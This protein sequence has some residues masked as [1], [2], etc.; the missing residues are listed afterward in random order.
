MSGIRVVQIDREERLEFAEEGI[1]GILLGADNHASY[2]VGIIPPGGRQRRHIQQRPDDGTEIIFF[3]A[4]RFA[5]EADGT[6]PE[7][8]DVSDDGPVLVVCQSGTA[9]SVVN[10]GAEPVRFFSVFAPPF[11]PGEITYLD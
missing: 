7:P 5:I 11:A 6:E 1:E 10:A 8:Y 2:T 4:G 3:F 9:M